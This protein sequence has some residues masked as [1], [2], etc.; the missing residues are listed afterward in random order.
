MTTWS[1][2]IYDIIGPA[3]AIGFLG[4]LVSNTVQQA[5]A[6][7]SRGGSFALA[8]F[9]IVWV[10]THFGIRAVHAHHDHL[11]RDRNADHARAGDHVPGPPRA[12]ILLRGAAAAVQRAARVRRGPGPGW[13]SPCSRSAASRRPPR[14]PQETRRPGKFIGRAVMVSLFRDRRVL[15]LHLLCQRDRLGQPATW[16]RSRPA[17]T[18][19]TCSATR[20]GEPAGGSS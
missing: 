10:L 15:R 8:T 4:Y 13:C 11:R 14:W 20:C 18:P 19:T 6:W 1:Y 2:L 17:R 12:R 3:G 5:S 16:R 7:T 9:A